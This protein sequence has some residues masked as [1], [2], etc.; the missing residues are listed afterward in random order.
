VARVRT[1][2]QPVRRCLT[3]FRS[4]RCSSSDGMFRG[5]ED[6]AVLPQGSSK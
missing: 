3:D 4:E 6:R 5:V 1:L 2:Q